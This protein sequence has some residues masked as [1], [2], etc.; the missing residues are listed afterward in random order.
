MDPTI[1]MCKNSS[2]GED[3]EKIMEL[4]TMDMDGSAMENMDN[5]DDGREG[6]EGTRLKIK[7]S[8]ETKKVSSLLE[9]EF[10]TTYN[11]DTPEAEFSEDL[12]STF[13]KNCL[14]TRMAVATSLSLHRS[15]NQWLPRVHPEPSIVGSVVPRGLPS[16]PASSPVNG[17]HRWRS[18][19][20]NDDQRWRTTMNNCWTTA[21]PSVNGGRNSGMAGS[22]DNTTPS[23]VPTLENNLAEDFSPAL[24][25]DSDNKMKQQRKRKKKKKKKK[26]K[27][28][29]IES[30]K[31][32]ALE[33]IINA[34]AAYAQE[35][36]CKVSEALAV[37]ASASSEEEEQAKKKQSVD[38]N[39]YVALEEMINATAED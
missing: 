11:W 18:M 31:D 3:G 29:S 25:T 10:V 2:H 36:I 32:V 1:V 28:H 13:V 12:R 9:T 21:G 27:K 8:L 6:N 38:N 30:N 34:T 22:D 33:E 24:L 20:A 15:T 39:K 23:S 37:L 16:V 19:L 26:K 35:K 7:S 17:D 5:G 14:L 4:G